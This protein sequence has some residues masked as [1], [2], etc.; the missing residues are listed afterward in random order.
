MTMASS[1]NELVYHF[2]LYK[3]HMKTGTSLF[4]VDH[5]E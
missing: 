3:L 4:V 2:G 1:Y 5:D